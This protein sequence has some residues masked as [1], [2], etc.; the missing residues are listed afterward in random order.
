[1]GAFASASAQ[2]Y[3]PTSHLINKQVE[4]LFY[5]L[6]ASSPDRRRTNFWDGVSP[7]PAPMWNPPWE[8]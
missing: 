1:M 6:H 5:L 7:V 4:P 2:I 3:P 8:G